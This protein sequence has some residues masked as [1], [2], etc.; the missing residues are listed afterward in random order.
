MIGKKQKKNKKTH[1]CYC[2]NL[3]VPN[4]LGMKLDLT[5]V[6]GILMI[7]KKLKHLFTYGPFG[8]PICLILCQVLTYFSVSFVLSFLFDL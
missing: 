3:N 4:S 2:K 5:M 6:I 8:F 1:P 7:T